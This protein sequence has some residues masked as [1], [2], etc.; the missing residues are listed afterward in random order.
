MEY[1]A[2]PKIR[3]DSIGAVRNVE[4]LGER[5]RKLLQFDDRAANYIRRML[6]YGLSLIHI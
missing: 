1:E 4:D 3:F 6:Y 2:A 5:L